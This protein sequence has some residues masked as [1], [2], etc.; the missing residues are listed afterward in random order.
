[1]MRY[2][3]LLILAGCSMPVE[4]GPEPGVYFCPA[5]DCEQVLIDLASEAASMKCAFYDLNLYDLTE[6]LGSAEFVLDH[7]NIEDLYYLDATYGPKN[8]QMHNK[9]CIF[10]DKI[11]TGSMNPTIRGTTMN[12][13]NLIVIESK[14]LAKNYAKEFKEMQNGKFSGGSYGAVKLQYNEMLIE[15]YFCPEDCNPEIFVDLIDSAVESVYFMVFSFTHDEIGDALIRAH[16]RGVSVA[17]IMEKSQKNKWCE[18]E[19]LRDAGI[20]VNWDA[21]PANMHH[22]VF[23]V[24]N[25][26]ITGSTNPSKNGLEHNDENILVIHDKEIAE[27][28]MEEFEHIYSRFS[29]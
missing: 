6:A 25:I 9:F 19:K 7:R 2:L 10:D 17:G 1:M 24:D 13:N 26:V 3:L 28:F 16:E 29:R 5:D 18:Y 15:N 8:H 4:T 23:I 12:N 21:N 11:V 27:K 20:D 14:V 22:K